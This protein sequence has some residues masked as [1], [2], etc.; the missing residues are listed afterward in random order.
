M[1]QES[2]SPLS[3]MEG[4]NGL[5]RWGSHRLGCLNA[6]LVGN[7]LVGVGVALLEEVYHWGWICLSTVNN[8]IHK[9][10]TVMIKEKKF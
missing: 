5:N 7:G 4:N 9:T 6:W 2:D 3:L 1:A 8:H 10:K